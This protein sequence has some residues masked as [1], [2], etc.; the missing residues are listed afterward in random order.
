M[1]RNLA[2]VLQEQG[3]TYDLL[4]AL[5]AVERYGHDGVGST[6]EQLRLSTAALNPL[7]KKL[8]DYGLIWTKKDTKT[9]RVSVFA[10]DRGMS[11]L[12]RAS[13]EM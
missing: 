4:R 10:T 3:L 2:A 11:V 12:K 9:R 6:A 13:K 5:A 1:L 8:Q 7:L